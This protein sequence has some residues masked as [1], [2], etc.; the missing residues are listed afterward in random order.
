VP[1]SYKIDKQRRLVI[2][3]GSGRMT[4]AE[5]KAHDLQLRNDPDFNS[6]FNQL[7]DGTKATALD[8]SYEHLR[9]TV[10]YSPFSPKSRRAF[11]AKSI[12]G[13]GM[14]RMT[15]T[16]IELSQAPSEVSVFTDLSSALNWLGIR[17]SSL[18][19]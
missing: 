18:H 1:I 4:V 5:M 8:A 6:E 16:L 12:H 17:D 15:A 10:R 13:F 14:G 2:S 9:E 7:L 19:E 11:V 3:T